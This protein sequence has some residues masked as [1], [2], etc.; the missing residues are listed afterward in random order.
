MRADLSLEAERTTREGIAQGRLKDAWVARVVPVIWTLEGNGVALIALL[1]FF[2]QFSYLAEYLFVALALA[3]VGA[4]WL[5]G[6]PLF[7]PTPLDR[8]LLLFIGW[9]LLT[10]PFATDPAYSFTEWR[11]LVTRVLAFSTGRFVS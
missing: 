8:P 5:E 9:V 4:L 1:C 10:V 6:K 7:A 2:P 11:K 3:G